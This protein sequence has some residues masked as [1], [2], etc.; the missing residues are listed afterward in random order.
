VKRERAELHR[1]VVLGGK[2]K[3]SQSEISLLCEREIER[4][5]EMRDLEENRWGSFSRC[6]EN[7]EREM[8]D[9]KSSQRGGSGRKLKGK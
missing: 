3:G 2:R 6:C 7:R 5:R 1:E 8:W 9:S 4:E